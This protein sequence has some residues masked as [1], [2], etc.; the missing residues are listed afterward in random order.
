MA[1]TVVDIDVLQTY[2]E[3][4][5][6]RAKHHAGKVDKIALALVGVII[7]R[8]DK[9]QP[10]KVMTNRGDTANVLWVFINGTRY[11]FSL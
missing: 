2:I 10:I 1:L 5:M 9:E 6:E 8:K 3:G 7:W 4:V 11:A